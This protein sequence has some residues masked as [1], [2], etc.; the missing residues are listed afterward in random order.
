MQFETQSTIDVARDE[1]A[2]YVTITLDRDFRSTSFATIAAEARQRGLFTAR[3][4]T[5]CQR[6]SA[7]PDWLLERITK[8]APPALSKAWTRHTIDEPFGAGSHP[9]DLFEAGPA[10]LSIHNHNRLALV[11]DGIVPAMSPPEGRWTAPWVAAATDV[12]ALPGTTMNAVVEG[13]PLY[14]HW[15]FDALPKLLALRRHMDLDAV[16]NFL[17]T[18]LR[19]PFHAETLALLGIDPARCHTREHHGAVVDVERVLWVPRQRRAGLARPE[20]YDAVRD[21]FRPET[22]DPAT[23]RRVYVSRGRASRRRLVNEEELLPII[24]ARGY[25]VVN[26]EDYGIAGAAGLLHQ[27]E[28]IIGLHGAG[29][30]NI[31]FAPHSCRVTE[32]H[33]PHISAEFHRI[34]ET[35]GLPYEAYDC[36]YDRAAYGGD[37]LGMSH[38]DVVVSK[39]AFAGLLLP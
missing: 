15:I 23:P 28:H 33:G 34:A 12:P 10:R 24:A 29:F 13:G 4:M 9:V 30:A 22:L 5:Q 17:F 26:F 32:L 37:S 31:V 8:V 39:E 38:A 21:L 20:L 16:D 35:F 36:G 14:S 2:E 1:F 7:L 27:A 19:N 11:A 6:G 3:E 18:S 25:T